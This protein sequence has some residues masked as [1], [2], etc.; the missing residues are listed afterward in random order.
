MRSVDLF[1]HYKYIN[2][3]L[4]IQKLVCTSS[5]LVPFISKLI[6][7]FSIIDLDNLD[8]VSL[9]RCYF[10]LKFFF[11]KKAFFIKFASSFHLNV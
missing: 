5:F 7:A 10:L 3:N 6:F 8:D 4:L 11:G 2:R 1:F 9:S